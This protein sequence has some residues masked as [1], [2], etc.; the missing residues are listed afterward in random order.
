M[1]GRK[2]LQAL[3]MIERRLCTLEEQGRKLM[4][5][6]QQ[7]IDA[8]N[9][10]DAATTQI[11]ANLTAQAA[12][13]QTISD[14]VDTLVAAQQAAGVPQAI[15]DQTVALANKAQQAADALQTQVPVL[16]AIATK[17]SANPVPVP[18]PTP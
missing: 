4:A 8:L 15:I 16:Q 12:V 1:L 17:G 6:Q 9:K 7:E 18:V 3:E 5:D 11:A 13:V 2:I 14:E 10:I